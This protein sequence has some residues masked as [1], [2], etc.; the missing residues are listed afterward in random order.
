MHFTTHKLD[1]CDIFGIEDSETG[2][3]H[4]VSVLGAGKEVFSL[5]V[6][7]APYALAFWREALS[8]PSGMSPDAVLHHSSMIELEFCNKADMKTPDL[9]LYERVGCATP[10]RGRKRWV[11]FRTYRPQSYPWFPQAEELPQ[12]ELGMRLCHRYLELMANTK[13]PD[14]FL[15]EPD[16][17][18]GLPSS[19][20]VFQLRKGADPRATK[21]WMLSDVGIDWASCDAPNT[22]YQPSEFEMYQL[23]DLPKEL[24]LW[25]LGAI[26]LPSPVMT[27]AGP[28]IPVLAIALDVKMQQPPEPHLSTNLNSS[29]TQVI[30]DCLKLRALDEGA[31]P[32]EIH[33]STD[34]TESSL[35]TF[36]AL[37]GIKIRR[38]ESLPL[39][40]TLFQTM[41]QQM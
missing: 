7:R 21:E 6:H 33:V 10:A 22:P 31:L 5:H 17:N 38:V 1:D 11:R 30:W 24:G 3:I 9:A 41:S 34:A 36:A 26:Y 32:S 12:L 35:S 16:T 8:D 40:G 2:G 18:K 37:A 19:L 29:P 4:I 25:E 14:R 28:V 27:K 13:N 20:K 39:L 15:M 23:A